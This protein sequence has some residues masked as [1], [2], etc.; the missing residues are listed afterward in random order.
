VSDPRVHFGIG[1]A[2]AVKRAAV[3]WPSGIVREISDAK[4]GRYNLVEEPAPNH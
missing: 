3:K 4:P 1:K 2:A